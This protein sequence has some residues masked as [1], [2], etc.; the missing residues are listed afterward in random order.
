METT[1]GYVQADLQMK[2]QALGKLA[3]VG[4]VVCR[5]KPDDTLLAFLSAL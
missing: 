2:E 3:P 1:H 4:G 5:F